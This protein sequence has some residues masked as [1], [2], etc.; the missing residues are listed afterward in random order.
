[1]AGIQNMSHIPAETADIRGTSVRGTS[2]LVF[3]TGRHPR[4]V[5]GVWCLTASGSLGTDGIY[6][7]FQKCPI[8]AISRDNSNVLR[9]KSKRV[10]F[11]FLR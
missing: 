11:S 6:L 9:T 4:Q 10:K 7:N 1:M 3:Y 8:P 5:Y 2:N